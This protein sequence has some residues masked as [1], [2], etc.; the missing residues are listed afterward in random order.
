MILDFSFNGAQADLFHGGGELA[1]TAGLIAGLVLT[2]REIRRVLARERR[3]DAQVRV[4]AGAFH[5]LL[6][7]AST[8]GA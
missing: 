5:D 1:A 8:T 7:S 2:A 6:R 3:L 4:A